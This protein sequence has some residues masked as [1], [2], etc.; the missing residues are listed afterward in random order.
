MS[1]SLCVHVCVWVCAYVSMYVCVPACK[2]SCGVW[3]LDCTFSRFKMNSEEHS[4]QH[5]GI[6]QTF[7]L[8][9]YSSLPSFLQ[10]LFIPEFKQL[11]THRRS[12]IIEVHIK[13]LDKVLGVQQERH[14]RLS[15][16]SGN[17]YQLLGILCRSLCMMC[18]PRVSWG[19]WG[20]C[21]ML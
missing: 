3:T 13:M 5:G 2:R 6:F 9:F 17:S 19:P 1:V 4:A 8:S 18:A 11:K 21:T 7:S 20:S 10:S 12:H 14:A 16:E 15:H